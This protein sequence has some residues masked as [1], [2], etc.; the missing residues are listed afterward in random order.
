MNNSNKLTLFAQ[1]PSVTQS[2]PR[3]NPYVPCMTFNSAFIPKTTNRTAGFTPFPS[4]AL[5]EKRK[6]D[7][8]SSGKT[9]R[10]VS[11]RKFLSV[12]EMNNANKMFFYLGPDGVAIFIAA[13]GY[14]E[15]L[16]GYW[17]PAMR[18]VLEGIA[19]KTSKWAALVHRLNITSVF[20]VKDINTGM[21]KKFHFAGGS[22]SMDEKCL[23]FVFDSISDCNSNNCT[24][25][26]TNLCNEFNNL[27]DLKISVGGN[28]VDHGASPKNSLDEILL[29][30]DVVNLAMMSYLD[31]IQNGKFFADAALVQSYFAYTANPIELF[32]DYLH[33]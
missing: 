23:V 31:A 14:P 4:H 15:G 25:I 6:L 24:A 7:Y 29:T 21:A 5:P 33:E 3:H 27:F 32:R 8:S 19:N 10:N 12:G 11:C 13:R 28:A 18:A 22:K 20:P 30:E 1:T 17:A 26:C 16:Y 9:I 2:L